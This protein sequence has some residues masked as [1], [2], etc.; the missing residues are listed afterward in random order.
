M[1][2][3]IIHLAHDTEFSLLCTVETTFH[4][5]VVCVFFYIKTPIIS[6]IIII[7]TQNLIVLNFEFLFL[8]IKFSSRARVTPPRNTKLMLQLEAKHDRSSK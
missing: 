8:V 3:K 4:L 7:F 1:L 5:C 2:S 6:G